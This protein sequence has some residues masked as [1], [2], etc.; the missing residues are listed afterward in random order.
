MDALC[1]AAIDLNLFKNLFAKSPVGATDQKVRGNTESNYISDY[2]D[3]ST[4][5]NL[6][7]EF[8]IAIVIVHHLR[9]QKDSDIFNQI[10]GS[11]GLQGAADTMMVIEQSN[12][13]DDYD[14]FHL[15]G[16]DVKARQLELERG[17]DNIWIMLSDSM[18]ELNSKDLKFV[19]A[20]DFAMKDITILI[21]NPT[22]LSTLVSEQ[23]GDKYSNKIITKVLRRL[24]KQLEKRDIYWNVRK[25]NGNRI[26]EIIKQSGESGDKNRLLN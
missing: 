5:K 9:K 26:I 17:E 18:H 4:L 11:T 12:R 20:I 15:V 22:D 1:F 19:N 21:T 7:D 16:R 2:D 23:S 6:A 13:G 10:T 24:S 25:S 3:I 14:T 8:K